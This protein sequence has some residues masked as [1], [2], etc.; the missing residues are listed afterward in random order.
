MKLVFGNLSRVVPALVALLV[1][2]CLSGEA[3]AA[4]CGDYV[5]HRSGLHS[6]HLPGHGGGMLD[7]RHTAPQAGG[8]TG[9]GSP[10]VNAMEE[11]QRPAVPTCSGPQCQR[12]LP[13]PATPLPVLGL[14]EAD[15]AWW[16]AGGEPASTEGRV[17]RVADSLDELRDGYAPTIDHPPRAAA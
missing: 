13:M 7:F 10:Y 14:A 6:S 17:G 9:S 15:S 5:I 2:Y 12:S 4:T 1:G 16:N 8:Q 11:P 3:P